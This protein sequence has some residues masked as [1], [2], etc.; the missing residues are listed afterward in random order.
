VGGWFSPTP[1]YGTAALPLDTWSHLAA[2]YDETTLRLY[3]NGVQVASRPQSGLMLTSNSPLSIG[4]DSLYGQYWAGLIDEV[5]IYNRALS[6]AEI[7]QDMNTPAMN[8]PASC[9]D[10]IDNDG[11][12]LAD[13][14]NDPGCAD[15]LDASERSPALVCDDGLDNDGDGLVDFPADPGC[16]S[17]LDTTE[18]PADLDG[19]GVPD[20]SDNC[21]AM[22]N[23]LQCDGDRDGYGNTCDAD[24]NNTGAQT[25]ADIAPFIAMLSSVP[26]NLT[27]D[28]NC[29]G[30]AT[31]GDFAPF[32]AR[33]GAS[34]TPGPSGLACAGTIPCP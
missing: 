15:A 30:S 5:R 1:L 13:F 19:D 7:S 12:G 2:T 20:A 27:A 16:S 8:P 29:N 33:L 28:M 25:G 22:A 3:V 6:T 17:P 10:G 4:G 34:A 32:I 14:P 23:P 21:V 26:A 11:D 24:I 31:G 18:T 9:G